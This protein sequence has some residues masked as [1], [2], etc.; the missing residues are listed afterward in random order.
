MKRIYSQNIKNCKLKIDPAETLLLLE[1]PAEDIYFSVGLV[2]GW[3]I[4]FYFCYYF[5]KASTKKQSDVAKKEQ[6]TISG[7][8]SS[9]GQ[10]TKIDLHITRITKTKKPRLAH[11]PL[12]YPHKRLRILLQSLLKARVWLQMVQLHLIS[13]R[14]QPTSWHRPLVQ[15]LHLLHLQWAWRPLV[16]LLQ[17]NL[18]LL[19][20]CQHLLLDQTVSHHF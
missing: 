12:P 18:R 10:V 14:P 13:Q 19:P 8:G 17:Q 16:L 4:D 6:F 15:L 1:W 5:F 9:N 3:L 11:Q 2:R 7:T 20:D